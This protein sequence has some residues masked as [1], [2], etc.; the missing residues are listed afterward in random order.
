MSLDARG[1]MLLASWLSPAYPVGAFAYSHGLEQA[2]EAGLLPDSAALQAWLETIL[3]HGAGRSD[4]VLL[5]AA[6]RDPDDPAPAELAAA[7]QPSAERALEATAQGEAFART[8][9]AVRG[10]SGAPATLPVALGRAAR[11]EDLPLAETAA[12]YL[13]A[14]ASNLVSA[15]IRLSVLGQTE[16][17]AV[18]AA[19]PARIVENH[20]ASRS[21]SADSASATAASPSRTARNCS[22]KAAASIASSHSSGR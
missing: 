11:R 17:Q 1:A 7:L 15:A 22:F 19:C 2:A 6:W 8:T 3:R 12:A 5:A 14:F 18:I 16:G 21:F 9:L 13:H 4:A 20:V 10:H